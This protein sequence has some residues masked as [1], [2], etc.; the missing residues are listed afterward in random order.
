VESRTYEAR[1]LRPG[2][3][4][5]RYGPGNGLSPALTRN[6][7]ALLLLTHEVGRTADSSDHALRIAA[8]CNPLDL[9]RSNRVLI[10]IRERRPDFSLPDSTRL[11]SRGVQRVADSVGKSAQAHR[12]EIARHFLRAANVGDGH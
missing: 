9:N 8:P 11:E 4:A 6:R 1:A 7:A 5:C 3:K 10:S 12:L 2:R